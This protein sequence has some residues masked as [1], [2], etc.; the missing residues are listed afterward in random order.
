MNILGKR[1]LIVG[2]LVSIVLLFMGGP[3]TAAKL[4]DSKLSDPY[5]QAFVD[6][7]M[8]KMILTPEDKAIFGKPNIIFDS[9]KMADMS[10]FDPSKWEN[11]KGDTIKIGV[12]WPHSGPG[13]LNGDLAWA[14]MTFP[15]YDIN[16]R[17][18]ILVDGKRKKIA[19]YKV[20][21]MSKPDR[22][23][24]AVEKAILKDKVVA[25]IGTSGSNMMKIQNSMAGK[26]KVISINV[27]ALAPV[28]LDA[29]N[30]TRYAFQPEATTGMIGRGMAY[31]L[32]KIRKKEKKFYIICQD[33]SFG[34][35]MAEG[36]KEG[37]KEYYPE[38]ELVGEDYHRLFETDFAPYLT[39]VKA[40]GAE[41]IWTGDWL[42]DGGNLLKQARA[43][44]LNIPICNLFVDEPNS[45]TSMGIEG[46]KNLINIK[47]SD[48]GGGPAF[49]TANYTKY[50]KAWNN[51]WKKWTAAS[52]PYNTPLF[53][54]P[55][56]TLG[57]WSQGLYWFLSVVERAGSTDPEKI[58]PIWEGD[59]FQSVTGRM[60]KMRACDHRAIQGFRIAEFV[61]PEEQQVSFNIPPYYWY[62][63]CCNAGPT[64]NV[65]ASAVLPGIDPKSE[66]CKGK[67]PRGE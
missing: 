37:L 10:G 30:F 31:Y 39:K 65:P 13:A 38:A 16:R 33:Y 29:E 1:I 19:L 59:T 15:A 63:K 62:D 26:H 66:R 44:G 55:G 4:F 7:Y 21:T 20:D 5:I 49:V 52:A 18:G 35:G 61:P 58:I 48:L 25:L 27:G 56:G 23:R 3:C 46:T 57:Q 22:C 45:L 47:H 28:L 24:T 43:M 2:V 12:V 41:A 51:N 17:G 67:D 64:Y 60:Y 6:Q 8:D 40:S 9:D 14:C 50:Y 11:P 53:R 32:G 54:H 42:P 36:F 34:H